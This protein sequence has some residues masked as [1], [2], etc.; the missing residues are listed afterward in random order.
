MVDLSVVEASND[1]LPAHIT[2]VFVGATSGIGLYTLRALVRHCT[3][4]TIYF[5]GRSHDAGTRILSELRSTN[6]T[7]KYTFLPSDVSLLK[8]VDALCETIKQ[9]ERHLNLLFQSQ[10]TMDSSATTQEGLPAMASLALHSRTRFTL[11][12]LPLLRAAPSPRRVV[13]VL[14]GTKE[15]PI[16]APDVY[17]RGLGMAKLR[18]ES[19]S[20]VTLSLEEAA[21][22]A[23]EVSFVHTFPGPVSTGIAREGGRMMLGLTKV[24]QVLLWPFYVSE[25]ETGERH[26]FAATSA[27]FPAQSEE[28]E[29]PAVGTDGRVGSGVY[30][31]DEKSEVGGVGVLGTLRRS[32]D[33]GKGEWVW[34]ELRKDFVR[35]TGQECL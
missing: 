31:V 28:G 24:M 25:G 12:L 8:N 29:D 6:P 4:P 22:R 33:E 19:A 34:G 16:T 17:L 7:G 32:R 23:P 26:L 18:G 35:I 13:S 2:A 15:A 30:T 9:A 3:H 20:M 14:T 1:R 11:N 10:G 5:I 21:R 27:R